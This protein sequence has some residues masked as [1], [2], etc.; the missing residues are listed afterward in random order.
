MERQIDRQRVGGQ[1]EE[2]AYMI[3]LSAVTFKDFKS[4]FC[5][6]EKNESTKFV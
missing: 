1:I 3:R 6:R 2:Y 4:K 5:F